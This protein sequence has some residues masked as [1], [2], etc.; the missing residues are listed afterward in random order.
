M[1]KGRV[2]SIHIAVAAGT[3][4]QALDSAHAIARQGIDGDRYFSRTGFWSATP[5]AVRDMT[6]IEDEA[7]EAMNTK[8]GTTIAAGDL[9]RNVVTRGVAL[10]HL[11]GREFRVGEIQL[12]GTGLC[13]P[14]TYLEGL[15]R[16]GVK[17]AMQHR[18][19]LR[20]EILSTGTIRIGDAIVALD[21]LLERNKEIIRRYYQEMWNSW[22]FAKTEAILAPDIVF[23]GS[24]G[25]ETRG[26][27]AFCEY[28]RQVLGAFPDF[29]NTIEEIVSENDGVVARLTYRGTHR[30]EIFGVAPTGKIMEYAGAAFFRVV[31]G[32]VSEGWVLGDVLN[33]LR[34]LGAQKLP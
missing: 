23:R 28:M 34:Q 17:A 25:T 32:K 31:N 8:L 16:I 20:A 15:T 11:V 6:L 18:C 5:G 4:M 7:V 9:R 19:G 10:N 12:R 2:I 30:G 14:C 26:R 21:D 33:L 1:S 22:N 3:P 13:Q 27:E 29:H 24:L